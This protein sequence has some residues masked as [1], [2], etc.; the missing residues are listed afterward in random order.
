MK[1]KTLT[2][3]LLFDYCNKNDLFTGEIILKHPF[4]TK[5]VEHFNS[6]YIDPS[7]L[8]KPIE[9]CYSF[10]CE[11]FNYHYAVERTNA[12]NITDSFREFSVCY[13]LKY[14]D[15]DYVLICPMFFD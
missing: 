14:K 1:I 13:D 8:D 10:V 11:L 3:K 12:I 7:G 15:L 2:T 5:L 9:F 6:Y 4:L